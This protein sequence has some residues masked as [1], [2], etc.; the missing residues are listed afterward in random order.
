MQIITLC[1]S[2]KNEFS[3]ESSLTKNHLKLNWLCNKIKN[4]IKKQKGKYNLL[5]Q[6]FYRI[7]G[8]QVTDITQNISSKTPI[9]TESIYHHTS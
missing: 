4:K 7:R 3:V 6:L 5:K 8:D 2:W 9:E 1:D